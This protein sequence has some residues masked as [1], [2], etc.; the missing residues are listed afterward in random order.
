M[1]LQQC[2]AELYRIQQHLEANAASTDPISQASRA[3]MSRA[4]GQ[5]KACRTWTGKA[6]RARQQ[7]A[8]KLKAEGK[9]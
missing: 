1:D 6:I 9:I 4:I 5:V 2:E 8:M 7:A 3:L